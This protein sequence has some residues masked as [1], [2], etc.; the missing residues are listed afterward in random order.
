[1][2]HKLGAKVMGKKLVCQV[3]VFLNRK[4][5]LFLSLFSRCFVEQK[6]I[7]KRSNTEGSILG[8]KNLIL[9][10]LYAFFGIKKR[11]HFL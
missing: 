11:T 6:W 8:S 9:N 4:I 10:D 5:G 2:C 3:L 7:K 1:M